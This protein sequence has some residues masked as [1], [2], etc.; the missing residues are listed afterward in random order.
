[1][2]TI[3]VKQI[4]IGEFLQKNDINYNK[5]SKTER[6]DGF[7]Q[8]INSE[9]IRMNNFIYIRKGEENSVGDKVVFHQTDKSE[10]TRKEIEIVETYI[11]KEY[12]D[13]SIVLEKQQTNN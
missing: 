5:N 12:D 13:V 10:Y 3:N 2:K 1:M 8:I 6:I 7:G 11:A 9:F 4:S